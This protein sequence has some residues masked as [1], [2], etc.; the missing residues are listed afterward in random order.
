MSRARVSVFLADGEQQV[1]PTEVGSPVYIGERVNR[2]A[3]IVFKT[4]RLTRPLRAA[5]SATFDTWIRH[6][7][8]QPIAPIPWHQDEDEQFQLLSAPSPAAMESFLRAKHDKGFSARITAGYCWPWSSP[9]G[10][11]LVHDIRIGDWTKPWNARS[12]KRVGEAP[13]SQLWATE[14]GGFEQIGCVYTAQGL[15]YDWGGVI[16]GPDLVWRDGWWRSVREASHDARV[17]AAHTDV[18]FERLIRNAYRILLTRAMC[19][20]IVYSTDQET[21]EFLGSLIPAVA[22]D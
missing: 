17:K 14:E 21:Q 12:V 11:E 3:P 5:G 2:Q 18:H 1:R 8:V 4:H 13:Q 20:M 22:H 16:L 10:Q 15:E 7:L 19:G 9:R 6:A